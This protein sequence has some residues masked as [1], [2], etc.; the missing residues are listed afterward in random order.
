MICCTGCLLMTCS[1]TKQKPTCW[2]VSSSPTAGTATASS[3]GGTSATIAAMAL[4]VRLRPRRSCSRFSSTGKQPLRVHACT[5]AGAS[6][7][8]EAG[9]PWK[10]QKASLHFTVTNHA[11][12]SLTVRCWAA[13]VVVQYAVMRIRLCAGHCRA[14]CQPEECWT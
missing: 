4:S 7:S 2:G 1:I 12:R 5:V 10:C 6:C 9:K 11:G 3:P 14:Q 13:K 8:Y